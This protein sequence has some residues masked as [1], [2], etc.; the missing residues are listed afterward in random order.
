MNNQTYIYTVLSYSTVKPEILF[1]VAE[2]PL[3]AASLAE[4]SGLSSFVIEDCHACNS[5]QSVVDGYPQWTH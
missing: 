1:I 3:E 2:S 4:D 5:V